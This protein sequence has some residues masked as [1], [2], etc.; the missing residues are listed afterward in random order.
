V[1]T[2]AVY[3]A[4][5]PVDSITIVPAAPNVSDSVQVT[6]YLRS[7]VGF[8]SPGVLLTFSATDS[9]NHSTGQ[10]STALPSDTTNI[11]TVQYFRAVTYTGPVTIV[12]TAPNGVVGSAA[13]T[14]K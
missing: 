2:K 6:A 4:L 3:F 1:Q 10:F 8:P 14:T 7:N 13:I 5:A 12:A 9:T 11:V